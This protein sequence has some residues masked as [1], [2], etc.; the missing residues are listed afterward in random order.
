M[1]NDAKSHYLKHTSDVISPK[2]LRYLNIVRQMMLLNRKYVTYP[3]NSFITPRRNNDIKLA[4]VSVEFL[5]QDIEKIPDDK[6]DSLIRYC[7]K[8]ERLQSY[9][10]QL[11]EK[12]KIVA[13]WEPNFICANEFA[14]PFR[15]DKESLRILNKLNRALVKIAKNKGIYIIAGSYHNENCEGISPIFHHGDGRRLYNP[16][17]HQKATSAIRVGEQINISYER[18]VY[19]YETEFGSFSVLICSDSYDA[20]LVSGLLCH[21]YR[22]RKIESGNPADPV[23]ILFVP[24]LN[25]DKEDAI[26]GCKNISLGAANIV[27]FVNGLS[28]N[29]H[30]RLF[31]VGNQILPMDPKPVDV[32]D[33]D[34]YQVDFNAYKKSRLDVVNDYSSSYRY[35]MGDK[36]VKTIG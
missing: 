35:M 17:P 6:N 14:F 32:E 24:S 29:K 21:N 22:N 1:S 31:V 4:S 27:L 8:R 36:P 13:Q 23:N 19:L 30:S 34:F 7:I 25:D 2:E 33:V 12:I 16:F 20:S 9:S 15:T 26:E 10:D 11:L 18:S 3:K 28:Y 5:E